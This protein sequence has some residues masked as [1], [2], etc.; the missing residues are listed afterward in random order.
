M[1]NVA[2]E[3]RLVFVVNQQRSVCVG[4]QLDLHR[5]PRH[6]HYMVSSTFAL[7]LDFFFFYHWHAEHAQGLQLTLPSLR[8]KDFTFYFDVCSGRQGAFLVQEGVKNTQSERN[9]EILLEM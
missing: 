7:C 8:H 9:S 4:K 3:G 1:V 2:K 6:L 5:F